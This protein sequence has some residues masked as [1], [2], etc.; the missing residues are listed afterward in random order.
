MHRPTLCALSSLA[1]LTACKPT[2]SA[3]PPPACAPTVVE[4]A[5]RPVAAV[6]P[7]CTCCDG[8]TSDRTAPKVR[9]AGLVSPHVVELAFSE[10]IVSPR[11]VDPNQF[12]ISLGMGYAYEDYASS[13]Y[14]DVCSYADQCGGQ[15]TLT[16]T[17]A[18]LSENGKRMRLE[19]AHP[20]SP[21]LCTV[22]R[23]SQREL[24]LGRLASGLKMSGKM[25]LFVHYTSEG[26]EPVRDRSGNELEDIG[27]GWALAKGA[28]YSY[29]YSVG[30]SFEA[31]E[32]LIPLPCTLRGAN[33]RQ[34]G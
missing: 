32:G 31:F 8:P 7:S 9:R 10:R 13:Y 33:P 15:E 19:L 6:A 1:A 30:T 2:T 21:D 16:F 25:G 26:T 29:Q 23:E 14:S 11:H 18:S 12:R 20:I 27:A 17:R 5:P 4:T 28:Q 34:S 24:L 3:D 22:I